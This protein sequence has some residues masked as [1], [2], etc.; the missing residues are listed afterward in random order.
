MRR[1]RR[2]ESTAALIA[3]QIEATTKTELQPGAAA[4]VFTRYALDQRTRKDPLRPPRVVTAA[5]QIVAGP[6]VARTTTKSTKQKW[7]DEIWDLRD[8]I[9]EVRFSG[10]RTARSVSLM[11]PMIAKVESLGDEPVEVTDGLPGELGERMFSDPS[12]TAQ[13][14]FRAA[15]HI[16]FNG[17]TLPII[18]DSDDDLFTWEPC[19]VQELTPAGKS[20]QYNDGLDTRRLDPTE[21][22]VR[23]WIP[24]PRQRA[25]ADCG[26]RAIL[27]VAR[28]LRGLTE[29]VSAQIDSRLAGAGILLVPQEIETLRGQGSPD[30]TNGDSDD[31]LDP[32]VADLMEMMLTPIKD[33]ASAA[34]LVPLVSKVP[35]DLVDKIKHIKFAE[36]LDPKAQEL[37]SEAIRRIALGMDSPPE[38]L[39]G[40]GSGSNHWSAWAISEE[41]VKLA[42]APVAVVIMHALTTG[43]LHRLLKAAG[44]PDWQKYLVWF[45]ASA[46]RLRP[47]RSADSRELYDRGELAGAAMLRENGFGDADLPTPD[48]KREILLTKLLIGA[49]SLA[50]LLLPLLGIEVDAA[51]LRQAAT[52]TDATTDGKAPDSTPPP[53]SEDSSGSRELPEQPDSTEQPE[54]EPAT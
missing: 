30:R 32:F 47:D 12:A 11:R 23:A 31:D 3:A 43:W 38:V 17:E 53:E 8:E 46:L 18:A 5:A 15:Q 51:V 22:V 34:A 16:S 29:H 39:L 36:P 37:R 26:A 4:A 54:R 13:R 52:I 27:P 50:P 14:L 28:E 24:H 41:D 35:G 19:S 25:W 45:D 49:P 6:S 40:L 1:A 42:V 48:Q 7:Q 2:P 33:R 10:D 44:I 9:G 20:W 21:H